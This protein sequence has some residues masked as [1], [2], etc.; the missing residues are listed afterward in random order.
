MDGLKN[1]LF[2][3]ARPDQLQ[4]VIMCIQVICRISGMYAMVF[5]VSVLALQVKPEFQVVS[6][7]TDQNP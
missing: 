3:Y 2:M 7:V 1:S 6:L 4:I 5:I